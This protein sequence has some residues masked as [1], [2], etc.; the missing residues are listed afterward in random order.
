ML[1]RRRGSRGMGTTS[2]RCRQCGTSRARCRVSPAP[3]Q[4][5]Q[6][7]TLREATMTLPGFGS[8]AFT[9]LLLATLLHLFSNR[10]TQYHERLFFPAEL[11][12]RCSSVCSCEAPWLLGA[13]LK[14]KPSQDFSCSWKGEAAQLG[15]AVADQMA[16]AALSGIYTMTR[17]EADSAMCWCSASLPINKTPNLTNKAHKLMQRY[18]GRRLHRAATSYCA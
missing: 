6:W 3:S 15:S 7:E 16:S 13:P 8:P 18:W 4:P 5:L 10:A 12:S 17:S 11:G 9:A 1:A 2:D 14:C